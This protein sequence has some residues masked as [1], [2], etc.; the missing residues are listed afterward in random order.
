MQGDDNA[1]S[2]RR[3]WWRR[4]WLWPAAAAVV[5]TVAVVGAL[6]PLERDHRADGADDG[7]LLADG[8]RVRLASPKVAETLAV[9]E[10]HANLRA[11]AREGVLD[12]DP[13]LT[14]LVGSVADPLIAA[15]RDLYPDTRDW[16]WEWHL[17]DTGDVNAWCLPGGRMVV[18]SGLLA[19]DVLDDDR[20]RLATVLAHEVAHALLQH[21]RETIGRA[22]MAQ[23]L[24]WT[25][26]KALKVG[27][28]REDAMV[29]TLKTALLDPHSRKRESEADVLGLELMTRAGFAPAKAMETWERMAAR[30]DPALR[31]AMAQKAMAFLS[32]HPSDSERLAQMGALQPKAKPLAETARQWDWLVHGI[33]E[34]QV[35]ALS[36]AANAFGLDRLSLATDQKLVAR[37]AAAERLTPKQA[38]AEIE[39]AMWETALD[40]GGA[41]QMG[42][43]AMVRGAGGWERLARIEAA[44]SKL[45]KPR[46]L[47]HDPAQVKR[48][49]LAE[50]DRRAALA[51]IER[52]RAYLDAPRTHRR[53]WRDAAEELGKTRPKARQVIVDTL[54]GGA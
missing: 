21:S 20:D 26:A 30:L 47:L 37:V 38:A 3:E 15:A 23:G 42:L 29:R 44:W 14:E 27:A 49:A 34:G 6:R 2:G 17:A 5:A 53:L 33:D 22:W 51:A 31:T 41:L 32:D 50:D 24:A 4:R 48:L 36:R 46:P 43:T 18:L 35:E 39:R 8:W 10:Y 11:Y 19:E 45:R 52:V 28:V 13:Y 54:G 16:A 9:R 12:A 7:A 25:M 1:K 40:Q